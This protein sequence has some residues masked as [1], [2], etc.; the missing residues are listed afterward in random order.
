MDEV[1]VPVENCIG[2]ENQGFKYIVRC[3]PLCPNL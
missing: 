3:P 1:K 2:Q